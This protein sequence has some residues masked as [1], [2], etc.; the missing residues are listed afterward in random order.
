VATYGSANLFTYNDAMWAKY[1]FGEKYAVTDPA[2]TAP[3]TRNV[4]RN[5]RFA[6][7]SED[8]DNPQ[9]IWQDTGIEVLQS[10]GAVFLT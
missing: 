7:A 9:S 4:F 5:Y 6:G 8:P 1:K 2:T 3:A 10:R